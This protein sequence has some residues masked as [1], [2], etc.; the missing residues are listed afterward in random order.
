MTKKKED[1]NLS[2]LSTSSGQNY[3]RT[4]PSVDESPSA[5]LCGLSQTAMEAASYLPFF[6][7]LRRAK[8][9]STSS[10]QKVWKEEAISGAGREL[11]WTKIESYSNF[12][13]SNSMPREVIT[14]GRAARQVT[15]FLKSVWKHRKKDSDQEI[16]SIP[17]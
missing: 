13:R 14:K 3:F 6:I 1:I 16:Q 8:G 7:S 15:A 17:K 2:S 9:T 11:A 10:Q 5:S 4:A 12:S